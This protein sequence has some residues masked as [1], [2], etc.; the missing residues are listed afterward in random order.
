MAYGASDGNGNATAVHDDHNVTESRYTFDLS[1]YE[2]RLQSFPAGTNAIERHLS[3]KIK[4]VVLRHNVVLHCVVECGLL[5]R[6]AFPMLVSSHE[7]RLQDT[8]LT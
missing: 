4:Q 1:T 3:V 7:H 2:S 6:H 8:L 5:L